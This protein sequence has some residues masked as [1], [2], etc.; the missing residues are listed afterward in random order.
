MGYIRSYHRKDREKELLA[1]VSN[2]SIGQ[3]TDAI[4]KTASTNINEKFSSAD[5]VAAKSTKRRIIIS[6]P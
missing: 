3:L 6:Q 5:K 4:F 1:K 2:P